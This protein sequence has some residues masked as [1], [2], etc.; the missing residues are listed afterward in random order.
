[1]KQPLQEKKTPSQEA[2][3]LIGAFYNEIGFYPQA[4]RCA[5]VLVKKIIRIL[6]KNRGY[7]QC[8][9]DLAHYKAVE[10]EIEAVL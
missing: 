8:T 10:V 1:M 6:E 5:L 2:K 3:E 7:T 9:I 4:K